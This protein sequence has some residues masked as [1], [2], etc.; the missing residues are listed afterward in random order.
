MNKYFHTRIW[1]EYAHLTDGKPL[2][3]NF[4]FHNP[5]KNVLLSI[6]GRSATLRFI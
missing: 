1:D 2:I 5:K 4:I 3:I 6:N